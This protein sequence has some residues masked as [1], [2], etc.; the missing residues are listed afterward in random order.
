M[1]KFKLTKFLNTL[2]LFACVLAICFL[3][4]L[5]F[6][7]ICELYMNNVFIGLAVTAIIGIFVY[8][9]IKYYE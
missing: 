8:A 5:G 2:L 9:Y 1:S 7:V 6:V 3:T 4:V